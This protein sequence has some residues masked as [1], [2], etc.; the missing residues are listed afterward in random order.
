MTADRIQNTFIPIEPSDLNDWT[1]N[2][3]IWITSS[4]LMLRLSLFVLSEHLLR[5]YGVEFLHCCS[6]LP[7]PRH[8]DCMTQFSFIMSFPSC[9]YSLLWPVIALLNFNSPLHPLTSVFKTI[10]PVKCHPW[11]LVI[12]IWRRWL[13]LLRLATKWGTPCFWHFCVFLVFWNLV[14][15]NL[16]AFFPSRLSPS[17]KHE[18]VVNDLIISISVQ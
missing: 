6:A 4:W 5:D 17:W 16:C 12:R 1:S 15:V 18:L 10:T 7:F 14:F 11:S 13:L 3:E 2:H 8:C 9:F